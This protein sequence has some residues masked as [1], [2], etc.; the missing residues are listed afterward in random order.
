MN[1]I[2]AADP[3]HPVQPGEDTGVEILGYENLRERGWWTGR[4]GLVVPLIMAGIAVYMIIGQFTMEVPEDVDMP[5]PRFFPWIII[6]A[7]LALAAILAVDIIRTPQL[8]DPAPAVEPSDL[9]ERAWYTDWK[10]LA[11]ALGGLVA[12]IV[13]I[14]PIGWI[15][16]AALLFAMTAHAIGS[17]R[18]LFD[19]MIGLLLS[20]SIYLVFAV[21]LSVDLPS[22]LVFAGG[23]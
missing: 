10:A 11:W 12:F 2:H 4:A 20:S 3:N 18:W 17:R 5:G 1:N 22:G 14:V 6:A 23:R 16:S 13:L 19:S 8:P 21:V 7:L 15:L 9:E